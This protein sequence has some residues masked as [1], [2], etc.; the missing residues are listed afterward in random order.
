MPPTILHNLCFSFLLGIIAIPREIENNAYAKFWGTNKVHYRRC[1]SGVWAISKYHKLLF[2]SK[3]KCETID[4]EMIFYP[5]ANKTYF[6]K[7][8]FACNLVLKV[9]GFGNLKWP[10]LRA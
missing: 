4:I 10:I 8:D 2:Q 1:A 6:H 7:N 3:V 9:Q 5:Q